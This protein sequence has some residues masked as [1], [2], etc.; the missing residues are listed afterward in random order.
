LE[1]EVAELV[2][3][4]HGIGCASG[5]DA[6]LL[7]LVAL[8]VDETQTVVTTPQS[9]FATAGA[10]RRLGARVD[11]VDV[12]EGTINL[13]PAA[14][15][16]FLV[17]CN[18]DPD[19]NLREPTQGKRVTTVISVDLFGRPC[20][21]A[22]LEAVCA[23]FGIKLIE[24]ACQ[25]IGASV[26][27]RGCGVFGDV[28]AFSFY[29]TKNLGGAGDAGLVTTNDDD[30]ADRLRRLRVHGQS[31]GRYVYSE[32]GWNSRLDEMQAAILRVKLPHLEAWND[33]R[34]AHAAAYDAALADVD[35]LRPL[36]TPPTDVR[37]VYHLYVVR[38]E[39]RD[40]LKE[41]LGAAGIGAGVYYPL[42]LHLQEC[43]G[44]MQYR[45]GE[46]PVA[47]GFSAE[48]LALPMY[49]ELPEAGRDR[50]L[51]EIRRFYAG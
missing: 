7:A 37:A 1:T 4:K 15:R 49:P 35:G 8:G 22:G 20:D 24:D 43:F 45:K 21:Y 13:D 50:V 44:D 6:L 33:A 18:R 3:A 23:E 26:A 32:I 41:H 30:L 2:G 34:R 27:D 38:A 47:E 46:L 9:F 5:S 36:D 25:A 42:P 10:V 29:P 17:N 40:A 39:R 28:A 31:S 48:A 12:E 51:E 16:R 19:G 11:F 14:L